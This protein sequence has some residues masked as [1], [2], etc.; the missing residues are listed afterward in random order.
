MLFSDALSWLPAAHP[1]FVHYDEDA[2]TRIELSAVTFRN[3]VDKTANLLDDLGV[4]EGDDVQ[5]DLITT[6]PGHWA[7]W[8]WVAAIWQRAAVVT[9]DRGVPTVMA[10]GSRPPTPGAIICSMHPL[11]LPVA[12]PPEDTTDFAEVL[13][14]PDLHL[15]E[16]VGLTSPAW[17]TPAATLDHGQ[18]AATAARTT[19]GVAHQPPGDWAGISQLLVAP[20]LGGGTT[21]SVTGGDGS[22]LERILSQERGELLHLP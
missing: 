8:V 3:W 9:A 6:H 20:V 18:I 17:A 11:N 13:A 12:E 22:T 19:A 14:Q 2:G 5:L 16:P 15:A 1:L 10:A 21:V 7:T 4:G